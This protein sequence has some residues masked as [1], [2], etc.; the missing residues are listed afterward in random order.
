MSKAIIELIARR[1]PAFDAEVRPLY[2]LEQP[3][4]RGLALVHPLP[5]D[6]LDGQPDALV[7]GQFQGVKGFQHPTGKKGF[8]D[9]GHAWIVA[10]NPARVQ[11][12]IPAVRISA[13]LQGV[14]GEGSI[15]CP[16]E[17]IEK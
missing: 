9:F 8:H 2:V 16:I 5:V 3:P 7:L 17:R 12:L 14:Q 4:K 11:G 10:R 13:P 15:G 1:E 6:G